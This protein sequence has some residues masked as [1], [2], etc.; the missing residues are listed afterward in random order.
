[1]A[2]HPRILVWRTPMTEEPD[3]LYTRHMVSWLDTTE[4]LSTRFMKLSCTCPELCPGDLSG[5]LPQK[6]GGEWAQRGSR[7]AGVRSWHHPPPPKR[8]DASGS[9]TVGP[10]TEPFPRPQSAHL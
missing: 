5:P 1:M 10:R 7:V 3:G 9:L 4:W 6:G 8:Q 2:T